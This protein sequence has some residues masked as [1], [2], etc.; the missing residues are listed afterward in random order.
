MTMSPLYPCDKPCSAGTH[1]TE[2][3]KK[4]ALFS[5]LDRSIVHDRT[6]ALALFNGHSSETKCDQKHVKQTFN[7]KLGINLKKEIHVTW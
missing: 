2:T 6:A 1:K 4:L 5:A 3:L 7:M